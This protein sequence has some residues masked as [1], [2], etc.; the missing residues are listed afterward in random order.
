LPLPEPWHGTLQASLVLIESLDEQIS[1]LERELRALGADH[2]YVPLLM[3]APGD[4]LDPRL[5][6][7]RRARRH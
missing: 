1:E 5:H 7:R 2:P 6:D 4:R 3:T